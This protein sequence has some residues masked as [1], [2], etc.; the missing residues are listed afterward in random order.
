MNLFGKENVANDGTNDDS[1][2]D[3]ADGEDKEVFEVERILA[4][5]YSESYFKV[6]R[7]GYKS[8][9]FPL[10]SD[11]DVIC[12]E[13]RQGISGHNL[14]L[15]E[16]LLLKYAIFDLPDVENDEHWDEIPY[17][18]TPQ[19]EFQM[20]IRYGKDKLLGP[21]KK[22]Q[23]ESVLYDHR[24]LELNNDDSEHL[25]GPVKERH[26]QV[27]NVIAVPVARA[28]GYALSSTCQGCSGINE[29]LFRLPPK[30][31]T[32]SRVCSSA[33]AEDDA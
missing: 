19:A 27:G 7:K 30:F 1:D 17:N 5:C 21:P 4:I 12:G 31:S 29:P 20:L 28:L 11:V 15:E 8:K 13:P 3:E 26:I 23:L 25:D 18:E 22:K 9:I 6:C 24:P 10:P 32:I 16:K 2:S 33:A 14:K